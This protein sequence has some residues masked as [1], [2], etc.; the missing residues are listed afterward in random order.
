MNVLLAAGA[1]PLVSTTDRTTT[2]QVAAGMARVDTES[3]V[4]ESRHLEAVTMLIGLGADVNAANDLGN[5]A[6]HAAAM[7]GFD[8]VTQLLV[9]SG[10]ATGQSCLRACGI[11][12]R[13][14]RG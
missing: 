14:L 9:D 8:A 6:L 2:L 13:L 7:A 12:R 1:K 3:L 5:T 10:Q 11:Q 4:P